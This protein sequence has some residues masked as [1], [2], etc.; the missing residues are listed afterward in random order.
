MREVNIAWKPLKEMLHSLQKN[1]II[2][3]NDADHINDGRISVYYTLTNK[4]DR[5]YVYL[6]NT[7]NHVNEIL[8]LL[9]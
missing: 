6:K 4:G 5:I 9:T 1:N 7:K 2:I 8:S 3:E